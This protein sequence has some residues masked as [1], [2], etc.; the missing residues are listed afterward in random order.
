M[1]GT[2]RNTPNQFASVALWRFLIVFFV[3]FFI[4][5]SLLF[6]IDFVPEKPAMAN[7]PVTQTSDHE[8]PFAEIV[9][10]TA[11][12]AKPVIEAPTGNAI[13]LP[14]APTAPAV[15]YASGADLPT[16]IVVKKVGVDTKIIE[17]RS[18]DIP[19]LD[20]ALLSGAVRFPGS[21]TLSESGDLLLFGH[22]SYLPVVRNKAFKA[23]NDL[24]KLEA[25][26]EITVYSADTIYTYQVRSVELA[27][28]SDG[29]VALRKGVQGLVLVTCNSLGAKE[30]RYI[31]SAD[32]VTTTP[33]T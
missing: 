21:A 26:D 4:M 13:N 11:I 9:D 31:I 2:P 29:K 23:F 10:V 14:V 1:D 18:S 33:L 3:T 12:A 28:A 22:Q 8:L 32:L 6:I 20:Q 17:P 25:G 7:E 15:A 27:Q 16:R 19:T 5:A 30:D 24:Q